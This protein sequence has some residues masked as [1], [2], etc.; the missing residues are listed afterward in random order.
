MFEMKNTDF[1]LL[2]AYKSLIKYTLLE[3]DRFVFFLA[4]GDTDTRK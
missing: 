4:D 2:T 3:A 1:V